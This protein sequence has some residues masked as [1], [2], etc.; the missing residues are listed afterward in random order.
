VG[1]LLSILLGLFGI[2]LYYL[3]KVKEYI[4]DD[5]FSAAMFVNKNIKIWIWSTLVLILVAVILY[6]EPKS[7]NVLKDFIG[8]DL[9]NTKTGWLLF[10][11]GLC[12][13]IRNSK[14]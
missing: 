7:N 11:A 3:V 1:T 4:A 5:T 2:A 12:G 9:E 6:I 13:L 8:L 10:G 14:K